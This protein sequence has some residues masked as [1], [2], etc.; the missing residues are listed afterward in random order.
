MVENLRERDNLKDLGVYG[1]IILK[2][3]LEQ[4]NGGMDWIYLVQDRIRWR[5]VVNAVMNLWV[6]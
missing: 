3:I 1:R 2:W 5:A 4:W 6:S